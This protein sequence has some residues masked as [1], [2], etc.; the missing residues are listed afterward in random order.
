MKGK[1]IQ[2]VKH[3]KAENAFQIKE[4]EIETPAAHQVQIEVECFGLNYADVM[5]RQGAY[6]EAPPLPS[7]L[8]YEVVGKI[9]KVG[10][11]ADK[12]WLGK[13]V[14]AFTRFGGYSQ[15]V[16]TEELAIA[17]IGEYDG[18]KATCLA[19]QYVTAYYMTNEAI[20]IY[21][22]DNILI[23]A[24]AGGVGTA[25]IQLLKDKDVNIIAKF[26]DKSK[27]EY[28]Q[29]MGVDHAIN[30]RKGDYAEQVK[31]ILGK[32]K[33]DVSFNP[34]GGKSFRKDWKMIGK[35]GKIVLFGGSERSD[36]KLGILSDLNFVRKMGIIIPFDLMSS[37]RS[38]VGINMLQVA[39]YQPQ[40]LQNCLNEVVALALKGELNPQVGGEFSAE[41]I[42]EAHQLLES[43]KSTGKIVVKW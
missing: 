11:N 41:Q 13:R 7:V 14:I 5:A 3:G 35:T 18:A 19:T 4:V 40:T 23:H 9:I 29:K 28:L 33:L 25:L 1:I 20:S 8:G 42:A 2:L 38:I 21:K 39:A 26:G 30:Y 37:S 15:Y 27:R 6:S 24:A 16:N 12:N 32:D 36:K 10:E 34:A 17:E 22:G 43:G 31:S